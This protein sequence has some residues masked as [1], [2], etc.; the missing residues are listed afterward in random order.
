MDKV[1][2]VNEPRDGIAYFRK[3]DPAVYANATVTMYS[4]Q[5]TDVTLKCP[6]RF[7]GA[8]IDKFGKKLKFIPTSDGEYT[9]TIK[10]ALTPTLYSWIFNF[11]GDIKI[12]APKQ[13]I[14]EY[15][16]QLENALSNM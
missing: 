11:G 15:R 1:E 7:A 5:I 16:K 2:I 6:D 4:G 9:V 10:A 14:D 12:T 13:A 3:F 8:I